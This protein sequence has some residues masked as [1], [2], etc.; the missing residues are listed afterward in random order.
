MSGSAKQSFAKEDQKRKEA[1]LKQQKDQ[2]K[3]E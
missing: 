3:A 1:E 2:E